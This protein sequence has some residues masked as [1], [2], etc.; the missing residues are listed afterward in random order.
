V[1]VINPRAARQLGETTSGI[2]LLMAAYFFASACYGILFGDGEPTTTNEHISTIC[3]T[4][5]SP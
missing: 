1:K 5:V 3:T 4:A 2:A